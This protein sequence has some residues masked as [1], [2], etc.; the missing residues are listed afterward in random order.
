MNNRCKT[1]SIRTAIFLLAAAAPAA[2]AAQGRQVEAQNPPTQSWILNPGWNVISFVSVPAD[3]RP[4]QVFAS[5]VTST[6][7]SLFT[8]RN[9]DGSP[10]VAAF[11]LD[12]VQQPD[13]AL[14][15]RFVWRALRSAR[16]ARLSDLPSG[17]LLP[18]LVAGQIDFDADVGLTDVESGTA[19]LLLLERIGPQTTF[20]L[21]G[22]EPPAGGSLELGYGW[23]L[24][25]LPFETTVDSDVDVLSLIPAASSSRV[26]EFRAWRPERQRFVDSTL[27]EPWRPRSAYGIRTSAPITLRPRLLVSVDGAATRIPVSTAAARPAVGPSV[28]LSAHETS[29]RVV[30]E[31]DG[32]GAIGWTARVEPYTGAARPGVMA[33]TGAAAVDGVFSLSANVGTVYAEPQTLH[34]SIDRGRLSPGVYLAEVVITSSHGGEF[35][36]RVE[37][38]AG[39]IDG[40]WVGSVTI[41][42]MNGQPVV[43]GWSGAMPDIDLHLHVSRDG[44][45]LLRGYIDSTTTLLWDADAHFFGSMLEPRAGWD[46]AYRT[47]FRLEGS[48]VP[49]ASVAAKYSERRFRLVGSAA[50]TDL[51]DVAALTGRYVEDALGLLDSAVRLEGRFQLERVREPV[52][53][54]AVPAYAG[55]AVERVYEVRGG[56]GSLAGRRLTARIEVEQVDDLLI[57]RVLVAVDQTAAADL[58]RLD[59]TAPDGETIVLH[60]RQ[61][62]GRRGR[63][64]FAPA[65]MPIDARLGVP[66]VRSSLERFKHRSA[67][68]VW[69]LEWEHYGDEKAAVNG[70]S[71]VLLGPRIARIAGRVEAAD[72]TTL[73]DVVLDLVGVGGF[74]DKSKLAFDRSAGTI[75]VR[76]V[77]PV[78]IDVLASA[79]GYLQTGLYPAGHRSDAR[80]VVAGSAGT[81]DLRIVLR[82]RLDGAGDASTAHGGAAKHQHGAQEAERAD[83]AVEQ[84]F[85][86]RGAILGQRLVVVSS[87]ADGRHT[88]T[89][90]TTTTVTP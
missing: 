21:T 62:P 54:R 5:M 69:T 89:A 34:V 23:H 52:T 45:G 13:P 81:D 75:E 12:G 72:G 36:F 51:G 61:Q 39:G 77:P 15:P 43:G 67:A 64:V 76:E 65:P 48:L 28:N 71:L 56:R 37:V 7:M 57:D 3:R 79:P 66:L 1:G 70:W 35:R 88:I 27:A 90:R 19:Y 16:V 9:P 50:N 47:R 10:L 41:D 74:L 8:A 4:E 83:A 78:R 80:G 59:L 29:L 6:G 82:R 85:V 32:G 26:D 22:A 30:L 18:E 44:R 63:V 87:G 2:G 55:R 38:A 73:D 11:A 40:Q 46:P 86:I 58:H 33:L 42:R 25:G 49:P 68:G 24:T 60:H 31:N 14:R 20:T 84:P 17:Y 53:G